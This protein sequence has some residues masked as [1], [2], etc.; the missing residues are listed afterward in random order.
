MKKKIKKTNSFF[1]FKQQ[2]PC[3]LVSECAITINLHA[4]KICLGPNNEHDKMWNSPASLNVSFP[5]QLLGEAGRI[6]PLS[7]AFGRRV[8]HTFFFF[9]LHG[10]LSTFSQPK[11]HGSRVPLSKRRRTHTKRERIKSCNCVVNLIWS[12]EPI[13]SNLEWIMPRM[14]YLYPWLCAELLCAGH[15][16]RWHIHVLHH[17][18][19]DPT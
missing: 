14:N 13:K 1:I 12:M 16:S 5:W 4:G 6:D 10:N 7:T 18:G 19:N 8:A 2:L 17:S 15:L 3:Y 11:S 9:L